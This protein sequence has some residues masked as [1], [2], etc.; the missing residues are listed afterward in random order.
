[1]LTL[2]A[3]HRRVRLLQH[4]RCVAAD[5]DADAGT[6]RDEP[7]V[8]LDRRADRVEQPLGDVNGLGGLGDQDRRKTRSMAPPVGGS[9]SEARLSPHGGLER[10]APAEARR[11]RPALHAPL[12]SKRRP[13]EVEAAREAE[14]KV[15]HAAGIGTTAQVPT[16]RLAKSR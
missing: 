11:R 14:A 10:R 9:R 13:E 5:G 12:E 6:D 2:R 3:V 8:D 16:S 7:T 1:M 4:D 15:G